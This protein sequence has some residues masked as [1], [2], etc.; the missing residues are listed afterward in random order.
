VPNT[1]DRPNMASVLLDEVFF[2]SGQYAFFYILV[3]L[4]RSVPE[5]FR[6]G[7]HMALLALLVIQSAVLARWGSHR[8]V[9]FLASLIVPAVYTVQEG[10]QGIQYLLDISHLFFW[11]FSLSVAT[12]Q[13]LLLGSRSSRAKRGLEFAN[14]FLNV[15]TFLFLYFYFDLKLGLEQRLAAGELTA[16]KFREALEIYNLGPGLAGFLADPTHVFVVAGGVVLGVSLALGRMKIISLKDRINELF[17][18]Y[19]DR[20]IRDRIIRSTGAPSEKK[21]LC[22]LFSDIRDFTTLSEQS[23]PESVTEM[24]NHYFT[25]W[26]EVVDRHHGVVDKYVGDAIMVLFGLKGDAE[27]CRSAVASATEVLSRLPELRALLASHGHPTI[28]RIGIG[29]HQGPVIVGDIGSPNRMNYTAIGDN[30]NTASRLESLCKETGRT[31]IVS[32][33]VYAALPTEMQLPFVPLGNATLKGRQQPIA[34][35]GLEER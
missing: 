12:L 11:V 22:V 20:D 31:L 8:A 4:S 1:E 24:L 27:P 9:R 2:Y 21:E 10:I 33:A 3:N 17:G 14:T 26:E 16:D 23:S 25:L 19:V 7:G 28:A 29:I 35:H 32:D 34:V 6:D 5:F 13:V 18:R 30:V 15:F